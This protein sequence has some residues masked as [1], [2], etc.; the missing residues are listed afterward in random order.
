LPTDRIHHSRSGRRRR[1]IAAQ[2][3]C[4]GAPAQPD[5]RDRARIAG[6][7]GD[8]TPFADAGDLLAAQLVE[9]HDPHGGGV[10]IA[11]EQGTNGAPIESR[12]DIEDDELA[13]D[14]GRRHER[15]GVG[16]RPRIDDRRVFE[17]PG[18]HGE[19]D[20]QEVD[21]GLQRTAAARDE[22]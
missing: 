15:R 11:A 10:A 21:T 22:A 8:R 2:Y 20:G 6:R 12:G 1:G 13:R 5:E 16:D 3:R 17:H 9:G 19:T 7:V 4:G 14:S 18:R